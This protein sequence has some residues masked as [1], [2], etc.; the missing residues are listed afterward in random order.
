MRGRREEGRE[1]KAGF[2]LLRMDDVK[3]SEP[4]SQPASQPAPAANEQQHREREGRG[5]EGERE[6]AKFNFTGGN[7]RQAQT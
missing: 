7:R 3:A 4:T 6:R 1:G 5:K 2:S